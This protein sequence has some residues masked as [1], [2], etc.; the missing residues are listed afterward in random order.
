MFVERDDEGPPLSGRGELSV[1]LQPDAV[2][3]NRSEVIVQFL[4]PGVLICCLVGNAVAQC[5]VLPR[6]AS[7]DPTEKNVVIRY[8]NSGTR[9]VQAVEFTLAR[10]GVGPNE[11]T[12]V[13]HFSAR[14]TLH[15]KSETTAVFRRPTRSSTLGEAATV[16]SLDVQVTRVAFTDQSTWTPGHENACKVTFSPR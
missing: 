8:Y 4:L 2:T 9:A 6:H 10:P 15:P 12:V 13:T 5:P 16:E 14:G 11:A 1:L 3:P 7:V